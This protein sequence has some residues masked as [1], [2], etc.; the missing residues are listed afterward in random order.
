MIGLS[1]PMQMHTIPRTI[2]LHDDDDDGGGGGG[3]DVLCLT[4]GCNPSSYQ[5]SIFNSACQHELCCI[6]F[7]VFLLEGVGSPL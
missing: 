4:S 5:G 7:F 6:G 2:G 3:G 1:K